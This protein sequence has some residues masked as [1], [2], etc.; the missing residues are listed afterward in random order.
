MARDGGDPGGA[1]AG[2]GE[3]G[4]AVADF[5]K[6]GVFYLGRGY[7]LETQRRR[8]DPILYDS[9]DLVT[10]AVCVGMTGSGKTGLCLSLLEE[11]LLDGIPALMVDPKGDLGNLLLTFPDLRPEDFR[12]WI[13]EDDARRK[14]LSPEAYAQ[15]QAELWR[16]GLAEWGQDGE[17]IRRLRGAAE[18][19]IYT[20][21]SRAGRPVSILKSF[22]A[23][24][25]GVLEDADLYRERVTTTATSLLG[26]LGI[27]ADPLRSR[28]HIL[29]AKLL[30]AAWSAGRDVDLVG[31]IHAIQAP[32]FTRIGALEL[33]A[34]YPARERFA[35]ATALNNLLAAPGFE[36]WL[37]GEPLDVGALLHTPQGR[38]RA[39]I[40]SIAHLGDAERMFF[41]SLLLNETLGWVRAQP[42]TTSLRALLYMDEIF[43]FLPPVANPPSKL[44]LLTLLKQARAF[45]VGVVLATQNP[46]DLDYKA[47]ANTGTWLIGRLQTERDR[48]RLLD[49]LEGVAAGGGERVDR[50]A[51]E[52]VLGGLGARVFLLHNVHE[53]APVVFETRWAMSYL[54]GPLTRA[55]IKTLTDAGRPATPAP[56]PAAPAPAAAAVRAAP[57]PAGPAP[58]AP[59]PPGAPRPVLPP[60]VPQHF[61]PVRGTAAPGARLLYLPVCLGAA[62][63]RFADAKAGVDVAE[64][65]LV[66]TPM[67]AEAVPVAWDAATPLAGVALDDL[68]AAP[69]EPAGFGPLPPAAAKARSYEAWRKDL[70]TWLYGSR[71]L[72]LLKH[73][74]SGGVARPGESERDFRIRLQEA[75]REQ[76][77]QLKDR[78]RKKYASKVTALEERLRRARQA[79][80]RE[81]EQV[82]QQGLQAAISVGATIL[83]ALLGR[84]TASVG[85]VGRAT[86]AARGM[87]RVFKERQDIGRARETVASVEEQLA[88]V[89]RELEDELGRLTAAGDPLTDPLETVVVRPKKTHIAVRL[90]ALAWV[91]HWQD[92]GGRTTPAGS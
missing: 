7:D 17:R 14:G 22:A 38:P 92:A 46:V 3:E 78:L 70:V 32:P 87:G 9:R 72:E 71:T 31:L 37:E 85:S 56:A 11:A 16:R 12:P 19:A 24:A 57:A 10:H 5:E 77:D 4:D 89:Q 45:G 26:L 84:K 47:L 39:A 76:R 41:V 43:G 73:P 27:E 75:A 67:R 64:E 34:F 13:N 91:P 44:P 55:Q 15:E 62:T 65:A 61:L 18:L 63:V 21:G 58:A 28:E 42:G 1:G 59:G 50:Q 29:L 74:A 48:A 53:D 8:E 79:M 49:G 86:T 20:P 80:A 52:R 6:L 35:L 23:P 25:A 51:L 68:E 40:F 83:G 88:V 69:R 36:A 82:S 90:I 60:D 66:A 2:P 54:R 81:Q 30:E 33:E